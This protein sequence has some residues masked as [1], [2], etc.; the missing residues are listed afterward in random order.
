M[1]EVTKLSVTKALDK[2]R[3]TNV[4]ESRSGQLDEK[5][6]ALDKEI[7]H[8]RAARHRLERDQQD[9]CRNPQLNTV[10]PSAHAGEVIIVILIV[11]FLFAVSLA[12][13]YFAP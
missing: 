9:S 1:A 3:G 6:N 10:Q 5:I 8:L 12:I 13:Y 4:P 2:L 11:A 7:Q